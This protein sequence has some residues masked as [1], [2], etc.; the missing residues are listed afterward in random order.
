MQERLA[1][2]IAATTISYLV[3]TA[4]VLERS[5][6]DRREIILVDVGSDAHTRVPRRP[7][8]AGPR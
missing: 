2:M 7:R 5:F 1:G 3:R 4:S 6:R 8:R